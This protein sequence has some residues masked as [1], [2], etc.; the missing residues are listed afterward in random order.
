MKKIETIEETHDI[1]LNIAKEFH[2]IC[3]EENIPYYMLGGTMLGAIRHTG[4]IPWDDDMDF[5]IP[6][7]HYERAKKAIERKLDK[8][9]KCTTYR[10]DP[11]NR[12]A[13]VKISDITTHIDDPTRRLPIKKQIGVNIDIFPLLRCE[14]DDYRTKK[15]LLLKRLY[16]AVYTESTKGGAFK[17]FI[18]KAL[19]LFCPISDDR[20]LDNI[21]K[22]LYKAY[23]KDGEYISNLLGAWGNKETVP[24]NVMGNPKLYQFENTS[25]YGVEAPHEYLTSLYGNDYMVMPPENKRKIHATNIYRE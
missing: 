25:F 5:G 10:N 4:F 24:Y 23:K 6:I 18:K 9:Y 16:T 19:R 11:G 22:A 2:K 21:T 17:A 12:S 15:L 1:L 13:F 20:M 3:E 7:E 14:A 8:Q